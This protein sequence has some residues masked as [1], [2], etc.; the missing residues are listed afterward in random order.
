V[1]A[2]TSQDCGSP[3]LSNPCHFLDLAGLNHFVNNSFVV[4]YG[5]AIRLAG[6][7]S[8]A[9]GNTTDGCKGHH[10]YIAGDKNIVSANTCFNVGFGVTDN[11][12][13]AV[14][15]DN[16][17]WNSITGNVMLPYPNAATGRSA[18]NLN[19]STNTIVTDN[20][21]APNGAFNWKTA[22]FI[23]GTGAGHVIASN[24][25]GGASNLFVRKSA[26]ESVTSSA[27]LQDDNH[28]V[29]AVEPNTTYEVTAFIIYDGATTGDIKVSF[30][31]PAGATLDWTPLGLITSVTAS[32]GQIKTGHDTFA[33]SEGVGTAGVG[34]GN[35]AV[36]QPHGLLVVG[37][38]AGSL[39]FRWAQLAS[40]ATA[41]TVLTGSWLRAQRV[42]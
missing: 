38:T 10:I 2:N 36:L 30:T 19:S 20:M 8:K 3:S 14:Y 6:A 22:G 15:V 37:A 28:L 23:R 5:A 39:T 35:R 1:H 32:T 16:V 11:T 12:V 7:H 24:Y 41:T 26:D 9:V 29:L 31:G 25:G 18:V 4:G 42:A 34:A 33:D 27:T 13:D 40:D 21:F 17:G